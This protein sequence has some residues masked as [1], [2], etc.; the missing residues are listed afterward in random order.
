[1][2]FS[3]LRAEQGGHEV[4]DRAGREELPQLMLAGFGVGAVL[5][6]FLCARNRPEPGDGRR[7]VEV[8]KRGVS[9]FI[10]VNTPTADRPR[11]AEGSISL[12]IAMRWLRLHR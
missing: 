7:I 9:R 8:R 3:K 4:R 10:P 1:M 11:R 2:D 6:V 12:Q 5:S